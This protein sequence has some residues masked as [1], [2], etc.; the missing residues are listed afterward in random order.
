MPF[1]SRNRRC[2]QRGQSSERR[3]SRSVRDLFCGAKQ[4]FILRSGVTLAN[5]VAQI[6]T[7]KAG[8]MFEGIA[9]AELFDDVMADA[10]VALAVK[11]AMGRRKEFAQTAEL[12]I[13]GPEVVSPF[14]DAMGFIDGEERNRHAAKPGRC[15]VEGDA[16]GER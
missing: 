11:A 5:D 2:H 3:Q 10:L 7:A 4:Q 16:L 8:D 15:A 1:S 14:G 13:F 12:A 6:G 9:K